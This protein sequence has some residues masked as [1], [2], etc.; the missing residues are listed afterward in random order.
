MSAKAV[1]DNV[2]GLSP[3][4]FEVT[5]TGEVLSRMTAD[6]TLIQTVV[7][8]SVSLALRNLVTLTGGLV[9]MFVTSVKLTL[10]VVAAVVLVR[11]RCFCSGRW[12]R[13]LSRQSQD[14][15]AD[16]SARARRNLNA[17][18]TVQALPRKPMSAALFEKPVERSFDFAR[19]EPSHA[20]FSQR[21]QSSPLLP[22]WRRWD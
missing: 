4:F 1:F 17:V 7:G 10:L 12:V 8:S 3:Q 5:R 18:P 11:L 13:K 6:T 16:T 19:A 20:P 21:L 14:S 15:I 22:A 9:L 2:L